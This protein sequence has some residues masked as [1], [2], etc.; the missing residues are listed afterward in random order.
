VVD[1]IGEL[2]TRIEAVPDRKQHAFNDEAAEEVLSFLEE[3]C[4]PDI[5]LISEM[6]GL[7]K[8][9]FKLTDEKPQISSRELEDLENRLGNLAQGDISEVVDFEE[10]DRAS[11]VETAL[12]EQKTELIT[13]WQNWIS[14]SFYPLIQIC[15]SLNSVPEFKEI[16]R[17]V[18]KNI[19]KP[20]VEMRNKDP[21]TRND[22]DAVKSLIIERETTW[23][24]FGD[25]GVDEAVKDFLGLVAKD[26][27]FHL[28]DLTLPVI[29]WLDK[30]KIRN[31]FIVKV[32]S[33]TN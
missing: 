1:L 15:R 33:E 22:V 7:Q 28:A 19:Q 5:N 10:E 16:V 32:K 18:V 30:Y 11:D 13:S 24:K 23:K 3:T 8:E 6:V 4:V 9:L 20:A 29:E 12:E 14:R 31:N 27:G 17:D 2:A 25:L 21:F 26:Q